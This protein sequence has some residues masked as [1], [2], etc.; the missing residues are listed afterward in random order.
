MNIFRKVSLDRLSSPEQLDEVMQITSPQSW[1][2]LLALLM[3]LLAAAVWGFAGSIPTTVA[4]QGVIV[5]R[6]GVMNVITRGSGVLTELKV[7]PGDRVRAQDVVARVAQPLLLEK[8]KLSRE[9]LQQ[10]RQERDRSVSM[11]TNQAR[12]RVLAVQRQHENAERQVSDLQEQARLAAEEV[13]INDDLLAKGLVTRQQTIAARQKLAGIEAQIA[14]RKADMKQMEA[15][16]F[17]YQSKPVQ[18]DATMKAKILELEQKVAEIQHEIDMNSSVITPFSGE[19]VEL[20]VY[21][22]GTV[23]AQ[24]PILSIQPEDNNLEVYAYVPSLRAKEII[25]GMEV[26]VS[27]SI[28]KREEYGYIRGDVARVADYPSTRAALMRNFENENLVDSL[29]RSGEAVTELR[30]VMKPNHAAPSGFEWSSSK[31]PPLLLS[32]G[33]LCSVQIVTVRQRPISLLFPFLKRKLGL[34]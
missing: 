8:L 4:G 15:Q 33:T 2:I 3:L 5:R 6:G 12:L 18:E 32:S 16:S 22:G 26:Q 11:Q 31:G 27:P 1:L 9:M 10:A 20:K 23:E 17:E 24:S 14:D 13:R 25:P 19:V 7:K 21:L 29:A 30:I 34:G 28:V